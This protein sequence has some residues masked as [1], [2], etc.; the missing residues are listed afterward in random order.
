MSSSVSLVFLAALWWIVADGDPASWTVGIPTVL[1]A[2]WAARRLG[3][4]A[5]MRLSIGGLLRF[6]PFFLWES[7][8]GG[9]DVASRTLGLRLRVKPG[10]VRYR[11]RLRD[12][13]ARV[14]LANCVSLLP[15]TLS[16]EIEGDWLTIHA[17]DSET[18]QVPEL[19]RL[20]S[21]VA[22]L[23]RQTDGALA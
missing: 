13:A 17:L 12:P 11:T 21:A 7:L 23:F 16:A 14:L 19:A 1:V 10:F 9:V 5:G 6:V 20:E 3:T 15:G 22:R 8:R 2:T 4:G 18:D